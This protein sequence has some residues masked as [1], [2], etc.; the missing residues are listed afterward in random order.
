MKK[1]KSFQFNR[2]PLGRSFNGRLNI[3]AMYDITWNK[4]SA[5]F[6]RENTRCYSCGAKSEVTDHLIAHKG[7]WKL[8][9]KVDNYLPLCHKCHNTLTVK[10]DRYVTQK[11][12]EKL[13]WLKNNRLK[14]M[15][16]FRVKLI[17][18]P[19]SVLRNSPL[20]MKRVE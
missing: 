17:P 15:I 5:A 11:L 9:W 19:I 6:L 8:F 2:E 14:N 18:L 4:F 10:F 3:D 13:L 12:N 16:D 20:P 1:V 7:D